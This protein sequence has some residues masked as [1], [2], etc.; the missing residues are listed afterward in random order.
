MKQSK[1]VHLPPFIFNFSTVNQGHRVSQRQACCKGE[2]GQRVQGE[3][4]NSDQGPGR[5]TK[6]GHFFTVE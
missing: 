2:R 5:H 6:G 4:R 3:A 1:Q